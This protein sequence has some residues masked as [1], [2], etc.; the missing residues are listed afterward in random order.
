MMI[1]GKGTTPTTPFDP[2]PE[3]PEQATLG[4]AERREGPPCV[5]RYSGRASSKS[6]HVCYAPIAAKFR[7][8]TK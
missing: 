1:Q 2:E 4:A 6:S 3:I 7:G 8:A 5:I